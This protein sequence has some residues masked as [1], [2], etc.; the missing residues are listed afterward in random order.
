MRRAGRAGR[1][2]RG[3]RWSRRSRRFARAA[4][5][6]YRQQRA[7]Q[8]DATD[9]GHSLPPRSH[10]NLHMESTGGRSGAAPARI[11]RNRSAAFLASHPRCARRKAERAISDDGAGG[12]VVVGEDLTGDTVAPTQTPTIW[13]STDGRTYT[14]TR[15]RGEPAPRSLPLLPVPARSP[16]WVTTRDPRVRAGAPKVGST[17]RWTPGT[18]PMGRRGPAV[19]TRVGTEHPSLVTKSSATRWRAQLV[20]PRRSRARCRSI[21]ASS[22][23]G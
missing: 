9:P 19:G 8:Q 15:S 7:C 20:R 5:G 23:T 17:T 3:G 11:P 18:R 12:M 4:G 13:H 21:P 16:L 2:D 1:G 22:A 6:R 14:P 10:L